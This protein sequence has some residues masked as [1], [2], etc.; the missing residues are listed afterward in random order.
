MLEEPFGGVLGVDAEFARQ[1]L[2]RGGRGGQAKYRT[3]AVFGLPCRTQPGHRGGLARPGRPDQDVES[4]PRRGDL[5]DGQDLVSGQGVVPARQVG[6]RDGG[7]C[8]R[9]DRGSAE[10]T[11]GVEQASL[12]LQERGGG[13][14]LVPF[15]PEPTRPIG[16]PQPLGSVVQFGCRD[17]Q[18][19]AESQ[20]GRAL[21]HGDP[22]VGRGEADPVEL[23]VNLGQDIGSTER[24]PTFGHPFDGHT[25]RVGQ[26]PVGQVTGVQ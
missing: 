18:R 12:G 5:F 2:G 9:S 25:G 7:H 3:R 22:L 16:P 11:S 21:G 1:H 8:A 20:V 6:L 24:G 10:L 15:G 23:A 13:V 4:A 19:L 17:E 14:D 26:D